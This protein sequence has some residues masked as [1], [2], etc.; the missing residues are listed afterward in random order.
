MRKSIKKTAAGTVIL[1]LVL[2][3]GLW[4]F[5]DSYSSFHRRMTGEKLAPASV[6][7]NSGSASVSVVGQEADIDLSP[8]EPESKLYC[9]AYIVS[10]DEFKAAAYII[11]LCVGF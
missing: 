9:A 3:A 7:L 1:Y 5:I 11:S 10:P 2:S 8:L 6:T 4:L